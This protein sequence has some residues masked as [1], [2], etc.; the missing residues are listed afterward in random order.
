MN[1]KTRCESLQTYTSGLQSSSRYSISRLSQ[2]VGVSVETHSSKSF[3]VVL[4]LYNNTAE[5]VASGFTTKV[6][7]LLLILKH[8]CLLKNVVIIYFIN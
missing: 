3:A 5:I 8:D 6:K 2:Q 1:W 4:L 7:I